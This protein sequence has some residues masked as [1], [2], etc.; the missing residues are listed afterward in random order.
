MNLVFRRAAVALLLV[1]VAA[2]A[3]AQAPDAKSIIERYEKEI[4][5]A[6]GN[7]YDDVRSIRTKMHLSTP[8]MG[9]E[10]DMQ[11]D[12]VLPD[13]FESRMTIPGMGEIRSGYDGEVAWTIDPMQGPRVLQGAELDQA[14]NQASDI[15][16][17]GLSSGLSGAETVGEDAVDGRKC[18]VVKMTQISGVIA[19]GCFDVENG[20]L[21]KQTME[22]G[23]SEIESFFHDYKSFGP[24]KMAS[25]IVARSAG[26]EQIITIESV[27]YDAFDPAAL[28]LPAEVK[29]LIRS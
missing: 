22:Q 25:R 13:R 2:P 4:G 5:V 16:R 27:E 15:T 9:M 18:W 1:G 6:G 17:P 10:F 19:D 7:P 20:L 14:R 8:A 29:A 21:V 11:I 26:M 28:A 23:G 3:S 24:V 12:A